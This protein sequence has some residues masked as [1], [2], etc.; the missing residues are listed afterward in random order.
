MR[1][2]NNSGGIEGLPLQLMIMI[3]VATLGTA[4]IIGWM[5]SVESPHYIG[6]VEVEP[7]PILNIGGE[8][9][10]S[11]RVYI[12]DQDGNPLE[13]AVVLLSGRGVHT[14]GSDKAYAVT[15]LDGWADFGKL[16]FRSSGPGTMTVNVS[17]TD[18]GEKRTEVM[19]I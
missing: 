10:Q 16:Q 19:V 8:S 9:E 13:G 4:I 12:S 2:A 14:P 17:H 18:Y 11:F 6:D 3:L 1:Y 7:F 5:G 15:G